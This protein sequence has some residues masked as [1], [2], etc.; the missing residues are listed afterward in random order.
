MPVVTSQLDSRLHPPTLRARFVRLPD[1]KLR[2]EA[3][4]V[5]LYRGEPRA[6]T[7]VAPDQPIG[8]LEI[9][10]VLHHLL[11]PAEAAGL[12]LRSDSRQNLP[13]PTRRPVGHGDL[14]VLLDPEAVTAG[15]VPGI[16][17]GPGATGTSTAALV[18]RAPTAGRWYTRPGPGK[19]P[20]IEV[21]TVVEHGQ[22]VGLIEVMKTFSRLHYGGEGLPA[23]ARVR[24]IVVK[25][26][27]DVAAGDTLF[28]LERDD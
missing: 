17:I 20:L 12:V 18:F 21:G 11:A 8:Q 3:P 9:L 28:E 14:L 24:A 27:E 13:H 6:G 16:G 5:G 4:T 26:E 1:G 22:A 25:D 23:R 2:L 19:P 10:G 7:L 15:A